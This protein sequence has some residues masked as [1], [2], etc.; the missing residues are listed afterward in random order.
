MFDKTST[1]TYMQI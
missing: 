1:I